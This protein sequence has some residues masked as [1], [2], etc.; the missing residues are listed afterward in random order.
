MKKLLL[1]ASASALMAGS[2]FAASHGTEVK[3]GIILGWTIPASMQATSCF[4]T[5]PR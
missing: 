2:A 1:A 4:W 5:V 3:I